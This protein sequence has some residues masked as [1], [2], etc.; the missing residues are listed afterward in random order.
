[1]ASEHGALAALGIISAALYAT[2]LA[3][4][5]ESLARTSFWLL[6]AE[7]DRYRLLARNITDVI[8]RHGRNGAVL[9]VSPAAEPLFGVG[10]AELAG[11]GLFD[12]VHVADRPAYLTALADAAALGEDRSV[13]FRIRRGGDGEPHAGHFVWVEMRCRPLDQ[14]IVSANGG[15]REVVAVLRDVSERKVQERA[16]EIA[17][18]ES[19]RANAAKSRF[20]ATMSHELRTP[21]NAIIGF[22]EM[23]A[24]DS[25][26]LDAARKLEY[27]KLINDSGRHLLS[28]VNGILD[29]SKMETGNFEITPEPFVPAQAI[30]SCCDLLAL[31]AR[32]AG[33]E[34]KTRI[35]ADLPEIVADRRAVNQILINLISNAIKFTP[36]GGRVTVTAHSDG[37]KLAL[38]VEDTGVGI[39][40]DDL[41]RL[42]E[43]FFQ[44]RASYDRRHDGSGLGLSIVKGL[45]RLHDGDIDIRSRLGEGTRV[46]VRLPINGEAGRPAVD[47]IKLVTVRAGEF[48]A[49]ANVLVRKS[50]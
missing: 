38:V 15:E 2:G 35:A 23:L 31:K 49:A 8:T 20:L 28:V 24:N 7:E 9:F 36:R 19:E 41:P 40:E 27:A 22:S 43:A 13:E 3:L 30:A 29:M 1:M 42:G 48:A 14:S 34:L 32:D 10:T 33:V 45:V 26:V 21:L 25:L 47:P 12:R 5:A 37:P 6:Y 39:G 18:T 50:A 44:A 46:V 11:H 17:R 16:L 4:G